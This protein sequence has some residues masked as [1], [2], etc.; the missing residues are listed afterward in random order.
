LK[1]SSFCRLS[2]STIFIR[3]LAI[4]ELTDSKTPEGSKKLLT[5]DWAQAIA[6]DLTEQSV[7]K[8]RDSK[9]TVKGDLDS[10]TKASVA[11]GLDEPSGT[12][13]IDTAVKSLLAIDQNVLQKFGGRI[14]LK[15]LLRRLKH[16]VGLK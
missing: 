16:R 8:I 14:L 13:Q 4:K 9:V 5:P 11:A 2:T 1:K 12:M 6:K 10:L 7:Q 3:E 15:E